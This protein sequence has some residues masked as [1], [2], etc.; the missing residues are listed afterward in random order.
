MLTFA[1]GF[2]LLVQ[3]NSL[4]LTEKDRAR[5]RVNMGTWVLQ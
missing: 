5:E 4:L 3:F 2:E 1:F